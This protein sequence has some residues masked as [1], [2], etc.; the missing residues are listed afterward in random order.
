[1]VERDI[2][3]VANQLGGYIDEATP[4]PLASFLRR[5]SREAAKLAAR[6]VELETENERLK[7]EMFDAA[8]AHGKTKVKVRKDAEQAEIL[9]S[10]LRSV[11]IHLEAQI[12]E[13]EAENER[14]MKKNEYLEDRN[15]E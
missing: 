2:Y 12:A 5:E 6:I 8:T 1:M 14:L 10:D 9:I 4:D 3:E 15:E 13:L 7:V 11:I